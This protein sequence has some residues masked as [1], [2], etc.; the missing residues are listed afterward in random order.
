MY[1]E[2]EISDDDDVILDS[3]D[4]V[5]ETLEHILGLNEENFI[6]FERQA[7]ELDAHPRKLIKRSQLESGPDPGQ[8]KL[9]H[10]Q[11]ATHRGG[12]LQPATGFARAGQDRQSV[13]SEGLDK[14]VVQWRSRSTPRSQRTLF[15]NLKAAAAQA[16]PTDG[17]SPIDS[18]SATNPNTPRE[19]PL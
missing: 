10:R 16:G 5:V 7:R 17:G 14:A 1:S 4:R 6:K 3:P 8:R 9:A 12:G 11:A 19:P 15:R 2:S 13:S 18:G